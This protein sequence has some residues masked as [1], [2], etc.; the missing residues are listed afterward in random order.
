MHSLS[1]SPRGQP[2]SRLLGVLL[3]LTLSSSCGRSGVA[4][5]HTFDTPEALATAVLAGIAR[6]DRPFLEGLAVSEVEFRGGVWPELPAARPERN[7]PWDYVWKDLRQK[8]HASLTTILSE[9]GG[10]RYQLVDI[11]HLGESTTYGAV[12]IQRETQLGIRDD[13]GNA[14]KVRL[15]GSTIAITGRY[16]VYS[17]VVD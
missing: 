17:Y 4:F 11:T 14:Q 2:A 13:K 6:R 12:E 7:V 16:K 8:S 3:A 5:Q 9:H 15:F 1:G 10:R